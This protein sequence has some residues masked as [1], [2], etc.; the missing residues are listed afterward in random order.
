MCIKIKGLDSEVQYDVARPLE[1]QLDNASEVTINYN[2]TDTESLDKFI[3]EVE[4]MRD[5]GISADI[6][7]DVIH[8][9]FLKGIKAKKQMSRLNK[10][11]GLNEAIK[12]LVTLQ[13]KTDK[14][15]AELSDFCKK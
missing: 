7:V 1:E 5:H 3:C 2:P 11:L 12:L 13:T 14:V 9:D 4:R 10:D 15:L 6:K 8:N